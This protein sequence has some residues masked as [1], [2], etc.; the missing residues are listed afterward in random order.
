MGFGVPL[1]DWLRGPLR[2]WGEDLLQPA[3]L[4]GGLLDVDAVRRLWADHLEGRRNFAYALWTIL[5]F[6]A[7]RRRWESQ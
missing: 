7:W 5:M 1:A 6:E 2:E 4:G 3:R